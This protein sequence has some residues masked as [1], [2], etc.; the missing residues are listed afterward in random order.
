MQRHNLLSTTDA[1]PTLQPYSGRESQRD[2]DYRLQLLATRNKAPVC[3][4]DGQCRST[5]AAA[6]YTRGEHLPMPLTIDAEVSEHQLHRPGGKVLDQHRARDPRGQHSRRVLFVVGRKLVY[7]AAGWGHRVGCEI[8]WCSVLWWSVAWRGFVL[9]GV[10]YCCV[11]QW[12][13]W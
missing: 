3:C 8:V 13:W 6:V 7:I 11:V 10:G 4:L 1:P 5:L 9:K 2:L 12:R